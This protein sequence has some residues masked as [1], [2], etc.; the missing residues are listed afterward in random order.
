[1]CELGFMRIFPA[2]FRLATVRTGCFSNAFPAQAFIFVRKTLLVRLRDRVGGEPPASRVSRSMSGGRQSA[3]LSCEH[4]SG[5]L[6]C[7]LRKVGGK[8][9]RFSMKMMRVPVSEV[10][11]QPVRTAAAYQCAGKMP[12]DPDSFSTHKL[13][14]MVDI[15]RSGEYITI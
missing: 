5:T 7:R 6:A 10:S 13:K 8:D 2:R 12:M 1:M 11:L 15:I 14:K 4:E 3:F 9:L